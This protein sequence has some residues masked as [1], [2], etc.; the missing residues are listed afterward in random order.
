MELV[1]AESLMWWK[2]A[3]SENTRVIL[4]EATCCEKMKDEKKI[5]PLSDSISGMILGDMVGKMNGRMPCQLFTFP[6][7]E[8]R[9]IEARGTP[10]F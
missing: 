5:P 6:R 3:C 9:G 8:K 10:V 2:L 4:K 7:V 1:K